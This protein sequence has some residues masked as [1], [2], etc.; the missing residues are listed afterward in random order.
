MERWVAA[1][2][3]IAVYLGFAL[4]LGLLAGYRRDLFSISEF[5]VAHRNMGVF[6]MWFMMGGTIFSAF[7]FMGGP[8]W[9]FS[10]GAASFYIL[11]YCALGLLPWY[12]IG[13]RASR[14]GERHSLI[15]LGQFLAKRYESRA[16]PVLV[17]LVATFA[18]VQ[19]ITLQIKGT[20]YIFNVL[21]D[22]HISYNAAA[23]IAYGIV[24]VY[25][26]TGGVRAAAWS[27][28]LQSLLMLIV[29]WGVGFYLV[30]TLQG[31]PLAMFQSIATKMPG[32]LQIGVQGSKMSPAAFSTSTLVSVLG[33]IMWPHLFTK[34][35]TTTPRRI[36]LTVMAYP[37]FAIFMVPVLYMGFAAIGKVD[38]KLLKNADE[39]VPYVITHLLG[40]SGWFYGLVG[41]GALAAAMSSAD[42][43]THGAA[44][45][46]VQD[47]YKVLKPDTSDRNTVILMRVAVLVVGAISLYV[48]LYGAAGLI[49][50]LLGAYGS[51]VQFLPAV[52]GALFWKRGTAPGAVAGLVAGVAVNVYYQLIVGKGPLDIHPGIWGLMVNLVIFVVLSLLTQPPSKEVA[53]DYINA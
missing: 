6:L 47:V 16:L 27:D 7:A 45:E 38:P 30:Y 33:F 26:A 8:G 21:T 31:G 37:V 32:F 51:I 14:I 19:Y 40:V 3:V 44:V 20:A 22:G 36:K 11:G 1:L 17:G 53:E 5:A 41:A 34:S 39:V 29:A 48:A 18:F 49:Q 42:A 4:A 25:V 23:C 15:S 12:V 52:Y 2:T 10:R 46:L 43:I 13:P 24:I 50:L 28:V 35:F 9:A